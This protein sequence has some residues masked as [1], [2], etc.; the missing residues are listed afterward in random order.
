[1]RS[2]VIDI[3]KGIAIYLVVLGHLQ[4]EQ[5]NISTI[6]IAS[7]HMP[8]FFF[9]SGYFFEKS[10]NKYTAKEFVINKSKT[11]LIPYLVWSTV[12]LVV[13]V[14]LALFL[15]RSVHVGAEFFDVFIN[16]RSVWFLI[17][18]YF[19]NIIVFIIRKIVNTNNW[20]FYTLGVTSWIGMLLLGRIES[21]SLYKLEWL[22]PYYLL[23]ICLSYKN[24]VFKKIEMFKNKGIWTKVCITFLLM[25]SYVISS[26]AFYRKDL[27]GEFYVRFDLVIRHTG[28]YIVYYSVGVLGILSI[29]CASSLIESLSSVDTVFTYFGKYSLDIYVIHMFMVKAIFII[30]DMI[31]LGVIWTSQGA[32]AIWALVIVF[33]ITVVVHF[34]LRKLKIYRWSLGG[35]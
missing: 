26:L 25:T 14:G 9:L 10:F 4:I 24:G 28:Y 35:R 12:A 5:C 2:K 22:F 11:L 21:F 19:T 29:I 20:L 7:C 1:M 23:G 30:W 27:F 33:F 13:N 16:A 15:G 32:L 8:V 34:I 17:V 6:L 18:L 31:S 3:S